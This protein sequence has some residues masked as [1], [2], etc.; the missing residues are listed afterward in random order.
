ML[1]ANQGSKPMGRQNRLMTLAANQ[2]ITNKVETWEDLLNVGNKTKLLRLLRKTLPP[3]QI[4][5]A[6]NE[7]VKSTKEKDEKHLGNFFIFFMS[8][9]DLYSDQ[10]QP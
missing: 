5:R 1:L 6:N 2:D 10:L 3:W 7:P 9:C 8:M 4:P